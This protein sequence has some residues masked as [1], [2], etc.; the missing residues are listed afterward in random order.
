MS[1][2]L[3]CMSERICQGD[4][5]RRVEYV[6]Y[7]FES[8]DSVEISKIVF[9]F[10]VVLSQDCDLNQDY[11]V[12]GDDDKKLISVIV[13]PM[14]NYEH[15]IC[16]QHLSELNM[17]MQVIKKGRT[18]DDYLRKNINPRYHYIEFPNEVPIVNSVIDFKHYFT[19]NG[20]YLNKHRE[21]NFVCQISPLYR[22]LL[23]QR[24]AGYLS[25]IGLPPS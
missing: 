3:K 14:Y 2:F 8:G 18:P 20:N 15:F 23:S 17:C 7:A 10:A 11:F 22:E 1:A 24:F 6:E 9:P 16:G 12:K 5:Y 25:R 4:V 13:V 19:V 21:S